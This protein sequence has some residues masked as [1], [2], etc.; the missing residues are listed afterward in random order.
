[1]GGSAS[2][3]I[4]NLFMEH[5][6]SSALRNSPIKPKIWLR[7]V[8]DTFVILRKTDT[9]AFFNHINS[10]NPH[11][12]FTSEPEVDN[13]LAFLDT[14]ITRKEGGSLDVTIYRKPTHT[15][16][17]LH[18]DSH[19]PVSHKL[20]VIRTLTHRAQT[21]V[22]DQ[23]ERTK[24]I[25]HIKGALGNCGYRQWA[26]DLANSQKKPPERA[27]EV[28]EPTP[29]S[30]KSKTYI[31][32]PFID[33]LSQKLQRI[34]KSYGVSTSFKPHTTLR[35]L[36]VSPKDPIPLEKR[37]GCVYQINYCT[38]CSQSYIGQTGRQLGQRLK[39]HKSTAPSRTPS[40]V[41]E[42]STD[43][44]HSIDWDNVKVLDR[45]DREY[46]R[47][48]REAIQI[49]RHT[50]QLNRDQGLEIPT[51]YTSLIRPKVISGQS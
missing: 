18:F 42:H 34:F 25:D 10:Q 11:I 33:G 4:A 26:F 36:L 2:P 51:L 19:H 30:Q 37:A 5:F 43:S 14:K 9:D 17:Y 38:D 15:D 29:P 12:K 8:D 39:E 16:Q 50:P 24:E 1:M 27:T 7:Y 22:T 40:A 6:E 45:E 47:L 28:P 13:H 41:T 35:K 20:S 31:T 23:Q 49:R 21:A 44:R 48:V 46:P 32:L 3:V